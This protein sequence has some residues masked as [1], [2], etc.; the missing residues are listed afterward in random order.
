MTYGKRTLIAVDQLINALLGGWPDETLSSRCYRW[1]RDGVRV[2]P[3]RVV[4]GL[5]FW[6]REHCKSSYESE[7]EGRQSPPEL[8]HAKERRALSAS[9]AV[10]EIDGLE[11][12]ASLDS[13]YRMNAVLFAA[14]L[15]A[16]PDSAV[17]RW[18]MSDNVV[19]E[20]SLRQLRAAY[21]QV[22]G[23]LVYDWPEVH[24]ELNK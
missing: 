14:Q 16:R 18:V 2:W 20:V 23:R 9:S 4:D 24:T 3:R 1:A 10:V 22:V 13:I 6:Q 7:R 19:R 12:D 5:F 17:V 15:D 21:V 11:F 8:R